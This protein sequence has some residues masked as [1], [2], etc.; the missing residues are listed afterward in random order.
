MVSAEVPDVQRFCGFA[1]I[2]IRSA[3]SGGTGPCLVAVRLK[4]C[5][6][7]AAAAPDGERVINLVNA[8][9]I[10]RI[11]GID[12]RM[13]VFIVLRDIES[14]VVGIGAVIAVAA[15]FLRRPAAGIVLHPAGSPAAPALRR[16]AK[17]D[18]AD[19]G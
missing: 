17:P 10:P 7:A 16:S 2:A 13:F 12:Q 6:F 3:V 1:G 14:I 9:K 11:S 5:V 18:G 19:K 15:G 4:S 8:V